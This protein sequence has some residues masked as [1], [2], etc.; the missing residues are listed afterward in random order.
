MFLSICYSLIF[1]TSLVLIT[2]IKKNDKPVNAIAMLFSSFVVLLSYDALCALAMTVVKIPVD[3]LSIMICN[4]ILSVASIIVIKKKT[5]TE[6]LYLSYA[7]L[8]YTL[9]LGLIIYLVA[10]HIFNGFTIGYNSGDSTNHFLFATRIFY[11]KKVSAMFF[12]PLYN[13][14][15]TEVCAPFIRPSRIFIPITISD[16]FMLFC[17]SAMIYLVLTINVETSKA[18]LLSFIIT[19]LCIFGYPMYSYAVG[20]FLYLTCALMIACF[21]IYWLRQYYSKA[22]SK[23]ICF[24]YL[25]IG[26]VAFVFT[27][28]LLAPLVAGAAI[29]AIGV[30]E[31]ITATPKFRKKLVAILGIVAIVASLSMAFIV[32]LYLKAENQ[33][34]SISS[35]LNY[36]TQALRSDGYMYSRVYSDLLILF[37]AIISVIIETLKTK[38]NFGI[39]TI[40]YTTFVVICFILCIKGYI[41]GYYYYKTYYILWIIGWLCIGELISNSKCSFSVKMA[42]FSTALFIFITSFIGVENKIYCKYENIGTHHE[43]FVEEAKIYRRVHDSILKEYTSWWLADDYMQLIEYS[44]D[45]NPIENCGIVIEQDFQNVENLLRIRL[46]EAITDN[47]TKDMT[48]FDYDTFVSVVK[49]R[50]FSML[51]LY[52]DSQFVQEHMSWFNN[53]TLLF[54]ND[55]FKVISTS[56][57]K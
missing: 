5:G 36:F 49:E 24:I 18:R 19:V 46:F 45:R 51:A 42:Y 21:I 41:S 37:P 56:E 30:N 53:T 14:L 52:K 33:P 23:L 48:E 4:I 9:L 15:F 13:A 54:E 17:V 10:N 34:I 47:I 11:T 25:S 55:T 6:K 8:L 57:L 7:D 35:A 1:L 20:G 28:A 2:L 3:L 32:A 43:G 12:D 40:S 27:Y 31:L 44:M 26:C 50:N 39:F 22:F 16:S 38:D 29:I